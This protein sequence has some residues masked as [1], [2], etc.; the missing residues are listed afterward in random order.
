VPHVVGYHNVS[1]KRAKPMRTFPR[2]SEE[3]TGM[4]AEIHPMFRR[5]LFLL[6]QKI[7]AIA[8]KYDIMD[9]G[10]NVIGKAEAKVLSIGP[11]ITVYDDSDRETLKVDGNLTRTKF[12]VT[13]PGGAKICTIRRPLVSF[14]PSLEVADPNDQTILRGSGK[15][16]KHDFKL[17]DNSGK[18]VVKAHESWASIADSY[19][20]ELTG[21]VDPRI[22]LAFVL[23]VDQAYRK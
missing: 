20:I 10:G 17:E 3:G 19:A 9:Q 8:S 13:Q 21:E 15:L 12:D 6:R 18:M 2:T 23:V 4:S 22:A 11:K 7:L 5:S 1:D 14:R 16:V